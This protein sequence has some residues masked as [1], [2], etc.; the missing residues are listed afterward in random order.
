M[1][2][3]TNETANRKKHAWKIE[4]LKY[5]PLE[6]SGNILFDN[7]SDPGLHLTLIL[8]ILIQFRYYLKNYKIF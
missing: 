5:C 2:D 4:I 7:S 6:N 8:K 3:I 1:E